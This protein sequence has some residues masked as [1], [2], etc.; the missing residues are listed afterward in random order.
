VRWKSFKNMSGPIA[1]LTTKAIWNLSGVLDVVLF[2]MTR[3]DVLLFRDSPNGHLPV[4]HGEDA[5]DLAEE[6]DNVGRL[7]ELTERLWPENDVEP[8]PFA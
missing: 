4:T 8:E 6:S 3:R 2:F 5:E 1:Q 7:P